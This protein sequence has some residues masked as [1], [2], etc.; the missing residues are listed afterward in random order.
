MHNAW[1][2]TRGRAPAAIAVGEVPDA[3]EPTYFVRD[4]GIGFDMAHVGRL[5]SPFEHV[6][7]CADLEGVGMGLATA[8]RIVQRHGGRIWAAG[9]VGHGATFFFTLPGAPAAAAG[10]DA[11]RLEA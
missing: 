11:A 10:P 7:D 3:A 4:S 8:Q 9:R 2:F 6:Q 5:F 1:K